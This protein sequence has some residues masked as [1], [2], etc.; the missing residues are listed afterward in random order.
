MS[1]CGCVGRVAAY[2]GRDAATKKCGKGGEHYLYEW[3][4]LVMAGQKCRF[5]E[6]AK[7][8]LET[9][10][11]VERAHPLYKKPDP[12]CHECHGSG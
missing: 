11:A 6:Y 2:A 8:W 1:E 10:D 3:Q 7:A 5:E 12:E 4:R 9:A